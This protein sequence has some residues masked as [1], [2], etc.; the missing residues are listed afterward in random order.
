MTRDVPPPPLPAGPAAPSGPSAAQTLIPT[1]NPPALIGYYV[2][3]FSLIPV[4]GA[5]LG[6][7]A[8]LLGLKGLARVRNEGLPGTAHAWIAIVLGGLCGLGWTAA[9]VVAVLASRS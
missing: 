9:I 8:F 5:P 7:V 4:L 6:I 1:R 3:V 2:A